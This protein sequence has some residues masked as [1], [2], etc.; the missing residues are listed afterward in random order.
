M[1]NAPHPSARRR[2]IVGG[3]QA[4][5]A[6]LL[7]ACGSEIPADDAITAITNPASA[8]ELSPL[9][10]RL[11]FS[12]DETKRLRQQI[13]LQQQA[14]DEVAVCMTNK[15][16]DYS[17]AVID[18]TFLTGEVTDDGSRLWADNNGLGIT[19]A[20]V[21]AREAIERQD[22]QVDGNAAYLASL[23]PAQAEAWVN[24]LSGQTPDVVEGS[25]LAYE[26]GGCLGSAIATVY[27][28]FEV[29]EHFVDKLESLN[30]RMESDPRVRGFVADWSMCMAALGHQYLDQDEMVDD[31]YARLLSIEAFTDG[32]APLA[33]SSAELTELLGFEQSVAVANFDCSQ[34]SVDGITEIRAAYEREFIEDNR[35]LI[36]ALSGNN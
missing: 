4:T 2:I 11:G 19:V 21:A 23:P 6:L 3:A 31:V 32:Q 13:E 10:E 9:E 27:A 29:V 5:V 33:E 18:E 22:G 35:Q 15:G 20:F 34:A 25:R 12:S 26:P 14:E 17:P 16:F 28:Q 1:A 30:A 8:T 24:A 36:E 7:S